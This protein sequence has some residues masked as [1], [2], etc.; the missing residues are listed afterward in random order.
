MKKN[1]NLK[2]RKRK[3]ENKKKK[4]VSFSV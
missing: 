4:V 1:G 2:E 3:E